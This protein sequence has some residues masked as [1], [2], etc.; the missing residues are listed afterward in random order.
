MQFQIPQ[1]IE[2]EDRIVGPLTLRQFIYIVATCGTGAMLYFILNPIVW[3]IIATPL[4]ALGIGL[5]FVKVN[6]QPLSKVMNAAIRYYWQPQT[7]VWQTEKPPAPGIAHEPPAKPSA[8]SIEKIVSGLALNS[9]WQ[10]VQT[11]KRTGPAEVAKRSFD[12]VRGHYE[13]FRRLSGERT[14]AKRVDYR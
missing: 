12:Q 5:S 9:A 1:F 6:G 3:F 2:T 11:G 4:I 7:Y 10:E 8:A 13:I 14:A